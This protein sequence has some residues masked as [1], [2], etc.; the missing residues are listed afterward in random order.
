M[1]SCSP[2]KLV[3][4][5]SRVTTIARFIAPHFRAKYRDPRR[6]R[7]STG[8]ESG[9]FYSPRHPASIREARLHEDLTGARGRIAELGVAIAEED[10]AADGELGR[11]PDGPHDLREQHRGE[12]RVVR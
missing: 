1:K 3:V 8:R 9:E 12:H 2:A 6:C 10:E 5:N 7:V 11:V 4:V